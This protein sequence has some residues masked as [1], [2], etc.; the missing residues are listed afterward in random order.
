MEQRE[1]NIKQVNEV[2]SLLDETPDE[3]VQRVVRH[4][5]IIVAA[6]HDTSRIGQPERI[7]SRILPVYI[8]A[9]RQK[10]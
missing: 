3:A 2:I 8:W 1:E 4:R 5:I 10:G 9:C 6:D 7:S